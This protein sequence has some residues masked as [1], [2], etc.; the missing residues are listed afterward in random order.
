MKTIRLAGCALAL[1]L[2]PVTSASAA[3][4]GASTGA[5][6]NVTA[7]SARLH[8]SVDPNGQA[9]TWSFEYGTTRTYGSRT[10]DVSAGAGAAARRVTADISGLAPN[11]TYHYRLVAGNASGVVSGADRAFKTSPQP[12]GLQIGATPNPVTYAFASTIT[13]TLTGTRSAGKQ[14]VLQ[15]RAFPYTTAFAPVGNPIVTD[16]SGAFSFPLLS[17]LA[18][19]QYRVQTVD[20]PTVTSPV[21]TLGVAVRVKTNVSTTRPRRGGLVRFSGTIR[22]ARPGAQYAIQKE[23]KTGWVTVAGSVTRSGGQTFSGFSK[24][25]RVRRSGHYRLFVLIVDGNLTSG[26]GRT[27][28]V[29]TR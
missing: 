25:I 27:V 12:L 1:A 3:T 15:S 13:G 17:V 14:V 18:T 8:G 23:T 9:T 21:L 4:P 24:R 19:S 7:S 11:T 2:V 26:I 20:K 6:S 29:R 22:P 16:A 5:T 10:P 28:P